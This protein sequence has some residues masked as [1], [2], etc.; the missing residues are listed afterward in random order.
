[1][2]KNSYKPLKKYPKYYDF[3]QSFNDGYNQL[4]DEKKHKGEGMAVCDDDDY[5]YI[6]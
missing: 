6:L 1:M 4:K 3:L 5:I 2:N